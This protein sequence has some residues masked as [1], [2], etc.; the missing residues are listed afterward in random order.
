MGSFYGG[1]PGS[2]FV[3]KALFESVEQMNAAF[4]QGSSYTDVWYGEHCIIDTVNKNDEDNGKIYQRGVE[5]AIYK[6]QIVGPSSGTPYFQME[7]LSEVK[8][9]SESPVGED[10]DRLYP[11]GKEDDGTYL[12]NKNNPG[13]IGVF[14]FSTGNGSLVP[15]KF[16]NDK[17]EE[18]FHD[19][20]KWTWL[21]VREPTKEND[22]WFYVGFEI[23]Y[24]VTEFTTKQV[25]QYDP[26]SG[27]FQADVSAVDRTDKEKHP[28]YQQWQIS[29]PKGI[30]GDTLRNLKVVIPKSTDKIYDISSVSLN[31]EKIDVSNIKTYGGLA[32]DAAAN[33][34]ILVF[35]YWYF[36]ENRTGKMLTFYVGDYNVIDGIQIDDDGT[37]TFSQT[38]ED[39]TV[40]TKKLRWID[41]IILTEGNGSAGGHIT[42]E[43]NND[44][45]NQTKEFDISWIKALEIDEDGSIVYTF[46][47]QPEESIIGSLTN[48][49]DG[50][51]RKEDFLRWV[52]SAS[53]NA[54]NGT[55]TVTDNRDQTFFSTQLD[56]IKGISI[57]NNG[58]LNITHTNSNKNETYEKKL[59]WVNQVSLSQ[60][61]GIFSISFNTGDT[62]SAQLDWVDGV[63]INEDTGVIRFHHVSNVLEGRDEGGYITSSAK[64]K[65][66][67]SA[68]STA[69]GHITFHTNTGEDILL[70]RADAQ[71][72]E[73]DPGFIVRTISD[74]KLATGINDDKH[75]QVLYNDAEGV[76]ENIGNP[77]NWIQD[78]YVRPDD[79]HLLVLYTDPSMRPPVLGT[80][81]STTNVGP[82]G[83]KWYTGI[84]GTNSNADYSSCYWRDLG[85]IKD[86]SGVLVGLN[87]S[88]ETV[89][90]SEYSN[91]ID[92]LNATYPMGLQEDD[93]TTYGT[94][95]LGKIITY[96]PRSDEEAG[97]KQDKE[98]YAFDYNVGT[99]YF[100]G[101]IAD[102]GQRDVIVINTDQVASVEDT[103]DLSNK[104]VLLITQDKKESIAL[105]EYWD[106]QYTGWI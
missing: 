80:V 14:D 64:L 36:D 46:A 45:P 54:E 70:E 8:T 71:E 103:E 73:E 47:G 13:E 68:T 59:K 91:I 21:N 24:M 92:Y 1:M 104:G 95:L 19:T 26:S 56:W 84:K 63:D 43:F 32:D 76:Y 12:Y 72:G 39:D 49:S 6:G 15:G 75:I 87:V 98:F 4:A 3:L 86:Q 37:V 22:S 23:P 16:L 5:G 69:D 97:T 18:D 82:D 66:I 105:P 35:D 89:E 81:D 77:L 88:F 60:N 106:P 29:V 96:T 99:W 38:H 55:F 40:F 52:K 27:N 90:E 9:R 48:V 25:D 10:E 17:Q 65:L 2:D 51:Y 58:T 94:S 33:R 78:I 42:F 83:Y 61:T 53:I 11:T 30:K 31:G 20:I 100:L 74:I 93:N 57:S 50:I 34:Q 28:F 67:T 62:Y 41:D 102:S 79:W 85:A 7:T 44:I 101:Q